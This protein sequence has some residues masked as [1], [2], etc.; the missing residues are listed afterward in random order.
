MKKKN[1]MLVSFE[2]II[3]NVAPE[4]RS[5]FILEIRQNVRGHIKDFFTDTN[6][7]KVKNIKIKK[8]IL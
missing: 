7:A 6:E 1:T 4:D 3:D 5:Y 2:M 8:V